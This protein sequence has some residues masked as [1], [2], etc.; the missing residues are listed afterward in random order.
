MYKVLEELLKRPFDVSP[1]RGTSSE[2]IGALL[3]L[4]NPRARLSRTETKGTAFSALGEFLWYLS[5]SNDLEF[6]SYYIPK[7]IDDSEDGKTIYGGYGKRLFN[8]RNQ[9]DQIKNVLT[10][11]S[12]RPA[13]R[14]AVIQLFDGEDIAEDHPEIPCTCTLQFLIRSGKLYMFTSMRSNDAYLGLPHDVFC[15]TML[16]EMMARHLKVD[17]GT[18]SHA[19]GSLHLYEEKKA[20]ATDYLTEGFQSTKKIMPNMPEGNPEASIKEVLKAEA[21]IRHN[22]SIN[23]HDIKV[24]AYWADLIRLLQVH[25]LFQKQDVAAIKDLQ[26]QMN[27]KLYNPY[28]EKKIVIL[29]AKREKENG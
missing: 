23:I 27:T 12:K 28:I 15:F 16:Q 11:L 24:D 29:E 9:H 5:K 13:S 21:A 4:E 14:K 3:H 25:S 17:V 7:Y 1:T 6:I 10:L 19:V 26:A 18:Y 2:I 8:L 20:Q 22:T